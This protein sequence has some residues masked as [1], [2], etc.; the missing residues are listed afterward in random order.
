MTN[1]KQV[2]KSLCGPMMPVITSFT[3]DLDLD[4][5]TIRDSVRF[6][7]DGGI[8]TGRGVI[9]GV[10]AGGDFPMLS[11]YERKQVARAIVDA[12][13]GEAPVL[14]SVQDT[15]PSVCLEL[16]GYA[17]EIGAYGI[18]VSPPSYYKPSA[19]DVMAFFEM[20]HDAVSISIMVYNTPWLG[21]DLNFDV[22]DVLAEMK[23]VVA[24]K[25]ASTN[26]HQY[27]RGLERYADRLAIV[28]NGG[29]TTLSHMMGATGYI[30]HLANIWPE[31]EVAL[32][33]QMNLGDYAGAQLEI[34]RANWR[35]YDFRIKMAQIT[36][37]EA[38]VVK[39]A[40]DLTGRRG[41]PVRPPTRDML[42]EHRIELK[43]LLVEM[44]VPGVQH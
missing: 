3:D 32:W 29:L 8:V 41:G 44:G 1:I 14:I 16:A 30:T 10:G 26:L 4:L 27:T 33:E 2:K 25:W 13:N 35:W 24:L 9:L 21:Y 5:N 38:N 23:R 18:Q 43:R 20:F 12:T 22:L 28:D 15:N 17:Q 19:R 31:H 39:A 40:F 42:P 6:L 36:S 11:V 34:Q 37:G 7:I